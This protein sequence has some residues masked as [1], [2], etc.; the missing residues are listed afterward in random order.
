MNISEIFIRR[1]IATLLLT[2]GVV[3]FGIISFRAL[4]LSDLPNVDFPTILVIAKL[5]GASP[6]TMASSIATPIE[7]QFASIAG[8]DTMTSVSSLGLAQVTLQFNLDRNIDDAALDVQ[9]ALSEVAGKLPPDMPNPPSYK[10][11]NP[12]DQPIIYIAV[13]SKTLPIHT[14]DE[15][16]ELRIAQTISMS[17]GVSQV[18]VFGAKKFAVRV[19]ANPDALAAHQ[20]GLDEVVGAV[21]QANVNLAT[22][23]LD[24]DYQTI[25]VKVPGQLY[26]AE[27][28]RP[29]IVAYRNGQPIRL[30][31]LANVLNSVEN[32]KTASWFNNEP[33]IILAVQK[34]PGTNTIAVI[35]GIKKAL[36]RVKADMPP[37]IKVDVLYDRSDSIRAS[38]LEVE[39]TL[40][41]AGVLVVLVIFI[42]LRHL[43]VTFIP[44]ISL[45]ISIIGTFALMDMYGFS[46]NT[47][48]LLALTLCVGFVIDDAIVMVENIMRHIEMGK[49]TL[50]ACLEGSKEI[51]FTI[52]SMS[53][54]LGAVFIPVL[55]MGGLLGRLFN[56]FAVTICI[57][58]FVSAIVSITLT[59]MLA[60]LMLHPIRHD[61]SPQ[62]ANRLYALFER[63]FDNSLQ[64]YK[65]TLEWALNHPRLMLFSTL[66]SIVV[67]AFLYAIIPKGFLPSED[68][69]LV[70]A[71]TEGGQEA[72]FEVMS[73]S[74]QEAAAIISKSP[75][76][77]AFMST[78]GAGGP[79]PTG[80]SGRMFIRLKPPSERPPVD[81]VIAEY[82][83]KLAYIPNLKVYVQNLPTLNVGGRISKAQ[84]QYTLQSTNMDILYK[85]APVFEA[86]LRTLPELL[87]V[88]SDLQN[89][90]PQ[91]VVQVNRDKASILGISLDQIQRTFRNAL[92]DPEISTIY[93]ETDSFQVISQ[94]TPDARLS[95]E[96]L[97][98]LYIRS[99]NTGE[100]VPITT[101]ANLSMQVGTLTINHQDQLPAVTI[102]FNTPPSVALSQ[103]INAIKKVETQLVMPKEIS[104]SFQS[105]AQAFQDSTAGMGLLLVL[106][107]LVIYLI[108]GM[109]Y[110]S[111]IHPITILSGLPSAGI[112]ALLTLMLFG[113]DLNI[114]SFFGIIMLIGI[115]KK[116]AIM[117]IDFALEAQKKAHSVHDAIYQA[118]LIRFRPIM[119]TTFAALFGAMP[120]ALA[121]GAGAESRKPLG[122]AVVGGLILSQVITLYIT[123]VIYLYLEGVQDRLRAKWKQFM[124]RFA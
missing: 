121:L 106:A 56:E 38:V 33:A 42:F 46:L 8:I 39:E 41:I 2:I 123:P 80:N 64:Y 65:T 27:E 57:A 19:Q 54:S 45:P 105:T 93:T 107:I 6:E 43:S 28:Y 51:G 49:P 103:A 119:M 35:E 86:K 32:D 1:P 31:Q 109:L 120:I 91:L 37:A 77:E 23:T 101:I 99:P 122:I 94:L 79:S 71:Y 70:F 69:N 113:Y 62:K 17:S 66:G 21:Q 61:E 18:Q 92:A 9:S 72:S 117:M 20:I 24:N 90:S 87:D 10:K 98:H 68:L 48:S 29:I 63:G 50:Q 60:S 74:Q 95:P 73:R 116:N 44:A 59:P 83:E 96:S 36:E 118:C 5:P 100:L 102:S 53:L 26:N 75:Y 47:V 124:A 30:E 76:I 4:P 84:Y 11:T 34:Q 110:E 104:A 111:L 7:Q 108:L 22:G 15:F 12:A 25:T 81:E 58:I 40:I 3:I 16:A 114:Y 97:S 85:W 78:I 67:A 115:V 112:G 88:N 89:K 13:S 52:I 14:V 55:F 82:R